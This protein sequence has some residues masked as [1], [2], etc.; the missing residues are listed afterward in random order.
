VGR[1]TGAV[2]NRGAGNGY[3][4]SDDETIH[5]HVRGYLEHG[6]RRR[7][8]NLRL[9]ASQPGRFARVMLEPNVEAPGRAR[10]TV[11]GFVG[12]SG[13]ETLRFAL[14]LVASELVK[15]AV[16]Y[17]SPDEPIRF[18]VAV[19]RDWIELRVTN[20]GD[21]IVMRELRSRREEG[22]RG[23]EIVDA[24]SWGWTIDSGPVETA[25]S[26]RMPIVD[27]PFDRERLSRLSGRSFG[28]DMGMPGRSR[29]RGPVPPRQTTSASN[30][31]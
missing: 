21:R 11:A 17:G 28:Y 19:H 12:A 31:S 2:R 22:G 29:D 5:R 13:S 24:L 27:S 15:N 20:S 23:L 16:L 14:Q 7:L 6:E 30:W 26:V 25:I 8:K 4:V 18:E 9:A 1:R 3:D 10:R